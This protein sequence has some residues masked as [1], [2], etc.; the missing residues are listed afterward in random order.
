MSISSLGAGEFDRFCSLKP[1]GAT[2]LLESLNEKS[3]ALLIGE[4]AILTILL[5]LRS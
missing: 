5:G 1:L 3:I 4:D 2:P